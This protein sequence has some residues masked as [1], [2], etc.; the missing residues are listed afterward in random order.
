MEMQ[1]QKRNEK[2]A[3]EQNQKEREAR[4]YSTLMQVRTGFPLCVPDSSLIP[5]LSRRLQ[6]AK[7]PSAACCCLTHDQIS[8]EP[9]WEFT[10]P[11]PRRPTA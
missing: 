3:K 9:N 1:E 11:H 4:S 2:A 10:R 6:C 5:I 8:P 7:N